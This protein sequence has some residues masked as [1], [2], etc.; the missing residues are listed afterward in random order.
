MI[1][2]LHASCHL[3]VS[4]RSAL[5]S[6]PLHLLKQPR[7]RLLPQHLVLDPRREQSTR[8]AKARPH[9]RL[10]TLKACAVRADAGAVARCVQ[11]CD[12]RALGHLRRRLHVG[13]SAWRAALGIAPPKGRWRE[14]AG[15]QRPCE[16]REGATAVGGRRRCYRLAARRLAAL[17]ALAAL[18]GRRC[19]RRRRRGRCCRRP[20]PAL[21]RSAGAGA[22][23]SR[24]AGGS[25][26]VAASVE[27]R[28]LG[29][30]APCARAGQV[31]AI[32][33]HCCRCCRR[34]C[35]LRRPA[36]MGVDGGV[37]VGR[38]GMQGVDNVERLGL[39]I[40]MPLPAAAAE[41]RVLFVHLSRR[42]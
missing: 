11:P 36:Q 5:R 21:S 22:G 13:D 8:V 28:M 23:G 34:S 18:V 35:A 15:G 37:S 29:S 20:L 2:A 26:C 4:C 31:R 16:L 19:R 39:G 10:H 3:H 24:G 17:A 1:N 33:C 7:P 9:R 40:P 32:R 27:R 30:H 25:G 38:K 12:R 42:T 6:Q 14:V 41:A